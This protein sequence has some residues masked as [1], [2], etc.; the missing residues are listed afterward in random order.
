MNNARFYD[1]G[2]VYDRPYLHTVGMQ[3]RPTLNRAVGRSTRLGLSH[4][5]FRHSPREGATP[6]HGFSLYVVRPGV[7]SGGHHAEDSILW[8]DRGHA[9]SY[10]MFCQAISRLIYLGSLRLLL[11]LALGPIG[12]HPLGLRLSLRSS[13]AR[14]RGAGWCGRRKRVLRGTTA[15]FDGPLQRLNGPIQAI[16]LRDEQ[17]EDLVGWHEQKGNTLIRLPTISPITLATTVRR[18]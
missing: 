5:S 1:Q 3:I 10:G 11:L 17:C 4:A 16:P 14:R 7:R 6:H 2:V 13:T 18:S 9:R 8:R 15:T 12:L